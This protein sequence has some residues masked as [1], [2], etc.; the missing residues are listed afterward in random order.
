MAAYAQTASPSAAPPTADS[1]PTA[2]PEPDQP[3]QPGG[4]VL[5]SRDADAALDSS[6]AIIPAPAQNDS[7]HVTDAERT[8]LSF[9]AY[10]LDVHLTPVSAGISVRSALT[11]RNDGPVS[12]TRIVLEISSSLHWDAFSTRPSPTIVLPL[13]FSAHLVDTDADHTGQMSEAVVS[14]P[15]PL[16]PGESVS[17]TALYSGTIPAS[18]ERLK[19][20]GAPPDQAKLAD[21]DA[22][23]ASS[24]DDPGNGTALRGFGNVLWYPVSAPPVFLGDGPKLF[25]AV[26]NT[27]LREST[28][29]I[30][31]HLAIEYTGEPPDAAFFCSRREQL[32]AISDNPNLP[33][34]ESPGIA[35]AT[36][37]SQPLGFRTPDLFIT[38]AAP[39]LTGTR[40]NPNLIA[41]VT[42]HLDALPAYSG[43]AEM[44]EPLLTDW[45]GAQPLTPLTILDHPG[46]PFEDDALLVQPMR[47]VEAKTLAPS[48]VQSL[49]HAWI[50][51]SYPWIDEGLPEFM[52][53]L[54]LE[55][56]QGRDAALAALQSAAPSIAIAEPGTPASASAADSEPGSASSPA[57]VA[58]FVSRAGM[59]LAAATGDVFYRT[60]A[61][62]VWWMLR[63]IVGDDALKDALKTYGGDAKLDRDPEGFERT[64]EKSSHQNLRWFFDDWIYRDQGLPDLS[65]VG[66][67]P[68]QIESRAG[69]PAGWLV[70]VDVRNDGYAVA[71]V[72]VTVR[73]GTITQTQRLRIPGRSSASTRMVFAGTPEEVEVNDGGVPENGSSIH[74]RQLTLPTH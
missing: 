23:A 69:L 26:G 74:T 57:P 7:L 39:N 64:L 21:W 70:G 44:V 62:A 15:H 68:S 34:A 10:G 16:T 40:S 6:S 45:L 5:F 8:A 59:S 32:I 24:P 43:A 63:T 58:P 31:L 27:K 4:K 65:I 19:R 22:I 71:D 61:T 9:I 37:D 67:T 50:H 18:A 25:Q 13:A 54:W 52:A 29:T 48:L 33:V 28:A 66:V 1:Q 38:G 17:L 12:L 30:R 46:E 60:K 55:R 20:I 47:A 36:F 51:S 53:L 56:N 35:S 14:L 73:S 42:N 3:L 11:V 41:A 2:Y 72:P 49:T